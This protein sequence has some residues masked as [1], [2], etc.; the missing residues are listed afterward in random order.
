M[1]V[2][3]T[4]WAAGGQ[5]SAAVNGILSAFANYKQ[6]KVDRNGNGLFEPTEAP[7]PRTQFKEILGVGFSYKF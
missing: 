1:K 4:N 7:G 6:G 5:N 3:L 2:K